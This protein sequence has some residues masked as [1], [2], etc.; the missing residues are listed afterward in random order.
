M[1]R[2]E[3]MK[4]I[5]HALEEAFAE[6]L[7]GAVL[8][9][10]EVRGDDEPSSDIDILVLLAGD[11]HDPGD[12]WNCINALYSL[13]LELGRPIHA[14]PVNVAEYEAADYPLYRSAQREGIRI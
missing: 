3:L 8:Y 4:R 10:S 7:K 1:E 2:D 5:K 12:S 14:E 9:G 6:R 13:T 11:P